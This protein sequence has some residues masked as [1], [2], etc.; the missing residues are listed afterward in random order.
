M[1]HARVDKWWLTITSRDGGTGPADPA[2]A[3]PKFNRNPKLNFFAMQLT[4]CLC[5]QS[6]NDNNLLVAARIAMLQAT[7]F[8]IFFKCQSRIKLG[9]SKINS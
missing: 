5:R 3:G 4:K 2:L 8:V 1:I 9:A 6:I 7:N